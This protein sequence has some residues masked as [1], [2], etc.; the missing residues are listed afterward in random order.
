MADLLDEQD[1]LQE[2][3][4]SDMSAKSRGGR[5]AGSEGSESGSGFGTMGKNRS[6]R[7]WRRS[8]WDV[9]RVPLSFRRGGILLACRPCRQAVAFHRVSR[10]TVVKLSLDHPRFA[11]AIVCHRALM[12]SRR[13]LPQMEV[14]AVRAASQC[15]FHQ[16]RPRKSGVCHRLNSFPDTA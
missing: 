3:S 5:G 16:R 7:T 6:D 15:M 14:T 12:A 4:L 9:A 8:V 13:D 2:T 10:V 1:R 11:S